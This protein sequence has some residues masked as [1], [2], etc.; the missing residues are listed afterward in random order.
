VEGSRSSNTWKIVAIVLLIVLLLSF[1]GA[2]EFREYYHKPLPTQRIEIRNFAV[3]YGS[4]FNQTVINYL[5]KFDLVI[6]QPDSPSQTN[7]SEIHSIKIAYIDLGEYDGAVLGNCTINVSNITIGNDKNWNQPIVNVS[8][9]LWDRHILCMVGLAL[10]LGF[11]GVIFDDLD[12][13]EQYPWEYNSFVRIIANVS[14]EYPNAIIGVNRGFELIQNISKYI[15]FVLYED[16]GSYYNF[17]DNS[18]EL[19][20]NYQLENLTYRLNMVRSFGLCILGLG[21]S[22]MPSGYIYNYDLEM[23]EKL[24]MPVYVSNLDLSSIWD[25]AA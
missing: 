4:S 19:L 23:G 25:E 21:Y 6:L 2:N 14:N 12:V 11:N 20:N 13:V 22:P 16:F 3:Y 9:E 8:S 5:N 17:T 24:N 18:Y 15:D 10:K 1:F 7:I